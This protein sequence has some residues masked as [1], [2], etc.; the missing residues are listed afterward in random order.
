MKKSNQLSGVSRGAAAP[1]KPI[2]SENTS[3]NEPVEIGASNTKANT[4]PNRVV[5]SAKL[6][7]GERGDRMEAL[8]L[9]ASEVATMLGLGRSKVYEMI[10]SGEL[11]V[12]RIGTAVRIPQK[13]LIEWVER[14]TERA[15]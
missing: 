3:S 8:L 13:A 5:T 15:A 14:H 12:V 6:T 1:R 9:R 11:P 4:Q 2:G 10:Q 7:R